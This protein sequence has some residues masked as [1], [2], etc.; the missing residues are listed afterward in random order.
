MKIEFLHFDTVPGKQLTEKI[1]FLQ[2]G[3]LKRFYTIEFG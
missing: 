2:N 1:F 3:S